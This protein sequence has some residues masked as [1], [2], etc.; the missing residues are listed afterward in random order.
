M[1]LLFPYQK[2]LILS[3]KPLGDQT[4]FNL[5]AIRKSQNHKLSLLLFG[6]LEFLPFRCLHQNLAHKFH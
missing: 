5:R 2:A 1:S 4:F 6:S 3:I